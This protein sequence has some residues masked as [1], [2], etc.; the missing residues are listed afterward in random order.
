MASQRDAKKAQQ[1]FFANMQ[2]SFLGEEGIVKQLEAAAKDLRTAAADMLQQN[3]FAQATINPRVPAGPKFNGDGTHRPSPQDYGNGSKGYGGY[4]S[5]LS[6]LVLQGYGT[7]GGVLSHGHTF[8]PR[9]DAAGNITSYDEIDQHGRVV[10]T[11]SRNSPEAQATY[12]RQQ[13]AGAIASS[14]Q[15]PSPFNVM[16]PGGTVHTPGVTTAQHI[17]NSTIGRIPVIGGI[18][19]GLI[20]GLIG[21]PDAI[22]NGIVNER[23]KNA[24]YQ[25]ILGGTNWSTGVHNRWLEN[26]FKLSQLYSGGLTGAMSEE[27]FRG[28]TGLGYTGDVRNSA[29]GLVTS[30]YKNLGM[31][32]DDSLKLVGIMAQSSNTA[33]EQLKTTLNEVSEAAKNT[34]QNL[35][36]A[37]NNLTNLFNISTQATG[38]PGALQT[39][40]LLG[41]FQSQ[42]GRNFAGVDF[43]QLLPGANLGLTALQASS[44]GMPVSQYELIQAGGGS[45]ARKLQERAGD[46][47]LAMSVAPTVG[48]V[49]PIVNQLIQQA[50]GLKAITATND[51]WQNFVQK[52][53]RNP[54]F[55]RSGV[56]IQALKAQI[57]A[58]TG[59][60]MNDQQAV[61]WLLRQS[62]GVGASFTAVDKQQKQ[63]MLQHGA[64]GY[65]S[66]DLYGHPGWHVVGYG[67]PKPG[68]QSV[69]DKANNQRVVIARDMVDP[70]LDKFKDRFYNE[71]THLVVQTANGPK[72]VSGTYAFQH[73]QDQI[74]KGTAKF[75][76]GQYDG[77]TV[78]DVVGSGYAESN[79][80]GQNTTHVKGTDTGHFQSLKEY[81]K[82][83]ADRV[84]G[85]GGK[86]IIAPNPALARLLSITATGN[87]TVAN[88]GAQWGYAPRPGQ[89]GMYGVGPN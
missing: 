58:Y 73:L 71:D 9:F 69:M 30:N 37:R 19:G 40:G 10:G 27:A 47:L 46:N 86:V 70:I 1:D 87:V 18:V 31:S 78:A 56:N 8:R 26:G 54:Q 59:A 29:L 77:H 53:M 51:S 67:P 21:A 61:E 6:S 60:T 43:S 4:T 76:G 3:S 11:H 74:A 45:Y 80:K 55:I 5:T 23:A 44:V 48:V 89:V 64:T 41:A 32:V 72:V 49:Q 79:Y 33:F 17:V 81:Q 68:Q 7:T 42:L 2:T 20:S 16:G 52:V 57:Q 25:A 12:Q 28:V 14:L 15:A 83:N 84:N 22:M 38:G 85:N 65:Q 66:G 13:R 34:G 63:A 50:G 75:I 62:A 82:K 88:E 36:L 24:Q 39:S 35:E